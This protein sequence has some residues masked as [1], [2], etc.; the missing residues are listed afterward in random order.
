MNMRMLIMAGGT[1]GHVFPALAV[2]HRLREQGVEVTWLGTRRGLEARV[3]PDNEFAIEYINVAGLRGKGVLGWLLAPFRL[4]YALSQA[5]SVLRRIKPGAVLGMGGFVTGP[6]G[7]ASWLMGIPMLVHEQNAIAGLTNKLLSR[8]ARHLMQAFPNTFPARRKAEVTGNPV[9]ADIAALPAPAER[10]A[11]RSGAIHVLVIGGSLGAL[12]LNR[13]LPAA[14]AQLDSVARPHIWHQCGRR[15]LDVTRQAYTEAGVEARLEPFIDDMAAA[16]AWADLVIC[17]AGALTVA[18]LAAAGV[19]S[20]LV[21]YPYAVDDHQT[22][23]AAY[24]EQAGAA[25]I[26]QQRDLDADLLASMLKDMS[27]K[28]DRLLPM[29][30]AARAR[31][32]I[33][34]TEIVAQRCMLAMQGQL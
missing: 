16:Y 34:A 10:F 14:V 6:G 3:V 29:A 19:G 18:E 7:L 23:N 13:L 4:L 22:A 17:R 2:A 32:K 27:E 25:L 11:N 28:R 30:E 20:I 1:G 9:R 26:V 24:L 31:A 5:I 15:H 8:L 12:A 21:P 33:N